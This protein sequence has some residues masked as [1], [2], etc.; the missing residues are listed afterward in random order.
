MQDPTKY[1]Y[2]T[3]GDREIELLFYPP[4]KKGAT[5]SPLLILIPGGGWNLSDAAS[6]YGMARAAAEELRAAGWAAAA[7][8]YRNHRQDGVN[9]RQM[10]ADILDGAGWLAAHAGELGIDPGR[11]Y[12]CGHSA[13]GHLALVL[14][15]ASR[16]LLAE[17]RVNP[18]PFT[19]R[20]AAPLS[21]P[22][23]LRAGES[24]PWLAFPVDDLFVG[25]QGDYAA[26]SPLDM[27]KA[28]AGVPT[29]TAVGER[30]SLVF[31]LNGQELTAALIQKGIPAELLV[32][33]RGGHSFEPVD[34]PDSSPVLAGIL[35]R[36]ARFFLEN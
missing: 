18:A 5:P 2:K 15:Y 27:V 29:L 14:A 8:S 33:R 25:C 12:T 16:D 28:G 30:D 22:V 24:R 17:E 6:M 32:S 36:I 1:I 13:G 19:V 31:P 26:F 11:F 7:L 23:M 21:P 35:P 9:M 4:E 34:A 10:V 20:A 3:V